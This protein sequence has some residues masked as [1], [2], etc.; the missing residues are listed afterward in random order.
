VRRTRR[1]LRLGE[2]ANDVADVPLLVAEIEVH[3]A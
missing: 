2:V 1:N 3:Y